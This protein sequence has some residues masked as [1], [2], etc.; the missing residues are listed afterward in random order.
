MV[1]TGSS[2]G[3]R[4]TFIYTPRFREYDLGAGHPMQASRVP[5]AY[6]VMRSCGVLDQPGVSVANPSPASEES[7]LLVHSQ[8]YIDAVRAPSEGRPIRRP[9]DYGL[10]SP[11][12]PINERVYPASALIAG[13]SILASDLVAEGT[14]RAAFNPA[15][16]LHHAHRERAAGFCFFN[17]AAIA[18]AHL[19]RRRA[20]GLKVAYVDLDAHHGDGVQEAFWESRQVLTISLHESG[21]YLFPGPGGEAR[22]LGEGEGRGY[23]VNVPLSPFTGDEVWLWAFREV[24]LPL[25][26]AFAPDFLVAQ[27]GCDTHFLDPITHM[28]LTTHGY[29]AAVAELVS[30]DKPLVALGGGGYHPSVVPRAWTLAFAL[31]AG[32]EPPETIPEAQARRYLDPGQA[33]LHDV[34]GPAVDEDWARVTREFAES[35]VR[36]VQDLIFPLH[37][38]RSA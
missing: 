35:S 7:L 25:L 5:R 15:G 37:G 31:M 3:S 13:A 11:D 21:R 4:A 9:A 8:E 1:D 28:C 27:I 17:D 32:V 38:I 20:D 26:D 30:L 6:R 24:V 33:S 18:I 19:L 29:A 2:A 36:E 22:D 14:T 10:G 16:G 23:S 34:E 12:N